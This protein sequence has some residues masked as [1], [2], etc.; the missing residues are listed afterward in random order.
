VDRAI[1]GEMHHLFVANLTTHHPCTLLLCVLQLIR[2]L[3]SF[4]FHPLNSCCQRSSK[5]QQL[6]SGKA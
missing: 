1:S 4:L 5:A 3:S 6:S 2:R